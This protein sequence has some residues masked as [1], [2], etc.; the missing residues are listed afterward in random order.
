MDD[1]KGWE[2]FMQPLRDLADLWSVDIEKDLTAY[3]GELHRVA[4][5]TEGPPINF[6]EAAVLVQNSAQ[7]Y[8][9]KVEQLAH[10]V[11]L[12]LEQITESK[13]REHQGEGGAG[14]DSDAAEIE[15]FDGTGPADLVEAVR[16]AQSHVLRD[17]VQTNDGVFRRPTR[18]VLG[19]CDCVPFEDFGKAEKN[20]RV[21]VGEMSERCHLLVNPDSAFLV[22][23][24]ST[25]G[26]SDLALDLSRIAPG[27][28]MQ[29]IDSS[30][31][32]Q[33]IQ[34]DLSRILKEDEAHS[35][36]SSSLS[37][38][39]DADDGPLDPPMPSFGDDGDSHSQ[40]SDRPPPADPLATLTGDPYEVV[41]NLGQ[42]FTKGGQERRV[43][44]GTIPHLQLEILD[45]TPDAAF[46]FG[47]LLSGQAFR[48]GLPPGGKPLFASSLEDPRREDMRRRRQDTRERSERSRE[49]AARLRSLMPMDHD[50]HGAVA[51][52][53]RDDGLDDDLDDNAFED[54]AEPAVAESSLT[55]LYSPAQADKWVQE[56]VQQMSQYQH[57]SDAEVAVHERVS[58]WTR[59]LEPLLRLQEKA[60]HERPFKI[61]HYADII[62]QHF[63]H[64]PVVDFQDVVAGPSGDFTDDPNV[65]IARTFLAAL[66]LANNGNVAL[67]HGAGLVGPA[68]PLHLRFVKAPHSLAL[69]PAGNAPIAD[70]SNRPPKPPAARSK[71]AATDPRPAKHQRTVQ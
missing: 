56:A 20:F 12:V 24:H 68:N 64:A 69:D 54:F 29:S 2:K 61:D 32:L 57:Q 48:N 35:M 33:G 38:R 36:R 53:D 16:T 49:E 17:F 67:E 10:L 31:N 39:G 26:A 28:G 11:Y 47:F 13:R 65:R 5:A 60:E 40:G 71:A 34:R 70:I 63:K 45:G 4:I 51:A 9:K 1:A 3:L 30:G 46:D 23:R 8:G 14:G 21:R 6:A 42:K 62:L 59:R 50:R 7:Y 41:H 55:G 37:E 58:S 66:Q 44:A 22:G 15:A 27:N 18:N 25:G 19:T 52:V 43:K